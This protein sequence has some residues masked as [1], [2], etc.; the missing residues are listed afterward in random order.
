MY[1]VPSA[2]S[3]EIAEFCIQYAD[4]FEAMFGLSPDVFMEVAMYHW[5][6]MTKR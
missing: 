1:R 4:D 2:C 3:F 5:S 6:I